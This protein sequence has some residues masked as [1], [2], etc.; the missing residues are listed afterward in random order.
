MN[1]ALGEPW[2]GA[3]ALG[4]AACAHVLLALLRGAGEVCEGP[5]RARAECVR[6]HWLACSPPYVVGDDA[7][8]RRVVEDAREL[9]PLDARVDVADDE[10]AAFLLLG[11]RLEALC[12]LLRRQ[13][14]LQVFDMRPLR[15]N[16]FLFE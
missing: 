10:E 8:D 16:L 6:C 7:C 3:S 9:Q 1:L 11:R 15:S 4:E 14:P 2:L 12:N 13:P 5:E